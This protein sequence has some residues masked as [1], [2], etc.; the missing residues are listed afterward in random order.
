MWACAAAVRNRWRYFTAQNVS[1]RERSKLGF[2]A[3]E[4]AVPVDV[5][6]VGEAADAF[7]AVANAE[8]AV[9]EEDACSE[10]A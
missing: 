2:A 9:A 1:G 6:E 3:F 10:A 4:A 5:A 7:A 8:R